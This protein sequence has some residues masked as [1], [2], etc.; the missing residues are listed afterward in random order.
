MKMKQDTD[1]NIKISNSFYV[2]KALSIICV[3]AAHIRGFQTP[4]VEA[5]R[6]LLGTLGVSDAQ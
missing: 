1:I 6:A 3:V 2:L 4:V 5:V